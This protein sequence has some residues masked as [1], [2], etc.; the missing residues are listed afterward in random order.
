MTVAFR[1]KS[2]TAALVV[3]VYAIL[4]VGAA[5]AEAPQ[6]EARPTG[7]EAALSSVRLAQEGPIRLMPRRDRPRPPVERETETPDES[8]PPPEIQVQDLGEVDSEAVGVLV[9]ETGGFGSEMWSGTP[10]DLIERLLKSIPSTM[11]SPVLRSLARRLLLSA[12]VVPEAAEEAKA[13]GRKATIL[14]QRIARLQAMGL[15]SDANRLIAVSPTRQRDPDIVRLS[16]ENML[17]AHDVGGACNEARRDP[18]RLVQP[19]WQKLMAF[20]QVLNGN[21]AAARFGAKILAED[22]EFD[23]NAFLA[24]VDRLGGDDHIRIRSLPKPSA[25]HLAMLRSANIGV[26]ADAVAKAPPPVLRAIGTSP[27]TELDLKLDAAERAALVGAITP[28]RMGEVYSSVEFD[29]DELANALTIAEEKRNARGR[30]LLFRAA[31]RQAVPTAKAAVMQKAFELARADGQV[32][33]VVRLYRRILTDLP[34]SAELAWFAGDAARGLL[35]L[36]DT[37]AAEPWLSLLRARANRDPEARAAQDGMWALALIAGEER[38][39]IDDAKA[40]A[41]WLAAQRARDPEAADRRAGLAISLLKALGGPVPERYWQDLV[42]PPQRQNVSMPQP[43][44]PQALAQAAKGNR[45][46]ETVL[47]LVLM[48][49]SAPPAENE[50]GLLHDAVSALRAIGMETEARALALEAALAHGL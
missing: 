39:R 12:A 30:A 27:H 26:P 45:V 23:D 44:Y 21:A 47:L 18:D 22:S 4:S 25:L 3:A 41:R 35:A 5:A 40:L 43:V 1:D 37:E 24:L 48:A 46:A 8:T 34:V 50:A 33:L 11:T 31:G 17:L 15:V 6:R 9:R 16:V 10:R 29:D 2:G 38:Y 7:G 20:C 42:Q 14:S 32:P 49:G 36:G 28:E 13:A 19:Y